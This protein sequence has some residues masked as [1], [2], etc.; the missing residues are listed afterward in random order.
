MFSSV[1]IL[2]L[3][4]GIFSLF[5]ENFA[6]AL[7]DSKNDALVEVEPMGVFRYSPDE[8]RSGLA[9]YRERRPSWGGTV[10]LLYSFYEPDYVPDLSPFTFEEAYDTAEFRLIELELSYKKNLT[11]GSVGGELAVGFYKNESNLYSD[12]SFSTLSIYPIRL[13]ARFALD[14]LTPT[15]Y[16]VPYA[17]GGGYLAFF[18]ET[19]GAV[20][21]SGNTKVAMYWAVGAMA[22]LDWLDRLAAANAYEEN[23][24]ES[25]FIFVEARQLMSSSAVEDPDL[26]SSVHIN[27]GLRLE[28]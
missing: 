11:I 3:F 20:S 22:T 14:T 21:Y 2:S 15:P 18:K 6:L 1:R 17:S 27:T 23:G 5:S 13:G 7:P 19:L 26:G 10:G 12:D 25:S 4:I 16:L 24:I 9:P 28:Y 8:G